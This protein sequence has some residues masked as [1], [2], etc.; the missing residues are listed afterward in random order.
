MKISPL[1]QRTSYLD[2]ETSDALKGI[3]LV[4]MFIHHFFT[5]PEWYVGGISYP[6]LEL[7]ARYL[8]WPLKICVAVFAFLTGYFFCFGKQQTF[9]YSLRKITDLLASYWVVYLPLLAVALALGCYQ[10]TVSNVV[11]DLFGLQETVM[12]FGWY[13]YLYIFSMLM[14][15]LM[16]KLKLDSLWKD[17]L[18]FLVVPTAAFVWL[19]AKISNPMINKTLGDLRDWYPC[20][21]SGFL[22]AKYALFEKLDATL[23]KLS[24]KVLQVCLWLVMIGA[25]CLG[26]SLLGRF[27]LG[28]ISVVGQWTDLV[29]TMDIVYAPMFVYAC[30]KLLQFFKGTILTKILGGLAKQSLL[31][32][33]IHCLFFNVCKEYTMPLLYFPKNPILVLIWGLAVCYGLARLIDLLVKPVLKLKNKLL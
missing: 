20:F 4:F 9:R 3:A 17:L 13:V 8:C 2:R 26:R 23:E 27:T 21:L 33:F 19:M 32:W 1:D 5:F 16:A 18:V 31:M 7:F 6:Y 15:P 24:S 11:L 10:L 28:T 14:L 29:Y 30:A 12:I 22:C 25:A